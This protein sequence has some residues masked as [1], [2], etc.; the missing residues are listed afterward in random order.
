MN[1]DLLLNKSHVILY[2][3]FGIDKQFVIQTHAIEILRD[4]FDETLHGL[5]H[6]T[7]IH[8]LGEFLCSR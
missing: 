5:L 8:V 2:A 4:C 3:L 7:D 1:I 6:P